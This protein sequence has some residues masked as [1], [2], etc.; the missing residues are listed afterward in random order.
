[1]LKNKHYSQF[2]NNEKI[3]SEYCHVTF[4]LQTIFIFCK[5]EDVVKI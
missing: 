4:I 5:I 1:M 3:E 2:L